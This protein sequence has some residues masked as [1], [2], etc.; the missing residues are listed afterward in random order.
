MSGDQAAIADVLLARTMYAII[1]DQSTDR[2][3]PGAVEEAMRFAEEAGD[4]I[5]LSNLQAGFAMRFAWTDPAVA[6]RWQEQATETARASGNPYAMANVTQLRG[7]VANLSA[8]PAEA[9][10]LF[11]E[12]AGQFRAIDDRNMELV[13]LSEVAHVLR[14]E[15]LL[16]DAEAMYRETIPGWQ[17]GGNRGAIANQLECFGYLALARRVPERAATLLGAAEV[18]REGAAAPVPPQERAEYD[19]QVERLRGLLNE[20]AMATAWAGGRS[21]TS[22]EAVAFAVS[23]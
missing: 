23:V 2:L 8:R 4:R 12:A 15:G 22:D 20:G 5:M 6:G 3:P 13:C 7:R 11:L 17:H 18:L 1:G 21:L 19:A 10:R 16:D 9:R 14:R